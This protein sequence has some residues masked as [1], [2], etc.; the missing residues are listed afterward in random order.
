VAVVAAVVL[1]LAALPPTAMARSF[2]GDVS[3]DGFHAKSHGFNLGIFVTVGRHSPS[4]DS[5]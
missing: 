1:G 5:F 2:R 4:S 3:L